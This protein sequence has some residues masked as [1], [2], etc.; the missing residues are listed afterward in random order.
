M[1]IRLGVFF[2]SSFFHF[3]LVLG[4]L[5]MLGVLIR[6]KSKIE[7]KFD[8]HNNTGNFSGLFQ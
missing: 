8:P 7:P 3:I 4:T 2:I 1:E 5:L 6:D